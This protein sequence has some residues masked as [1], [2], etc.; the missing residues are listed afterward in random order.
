M[1]SEPK[2]L[3][4]AERFSPSIGGQQ[5]YNYNLYRQFT[6]HLQTI[7]ISPQFY[8]PFDLHKL[9]F[10][11]YA[12]LVGIILVRKHQITHCAHQFGEARSCGMAYHPT[13]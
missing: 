8:L 12:F 6:K 10:L 11:L 1:E 9:W 4:I 7:I 2:L 13:S 3:F 5:T